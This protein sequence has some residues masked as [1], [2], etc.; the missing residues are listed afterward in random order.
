MS[1][2]DGINNNLEFF[3]NDFDNLFNEKITRSFIEQLAKLT[4]EKIDVK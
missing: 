2:T 1:L 4:K 3:F